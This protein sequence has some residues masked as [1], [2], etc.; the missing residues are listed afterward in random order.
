MRLYPIGC[1]PSDSSKAVSDWLKL[2][3][4][5]EA[6]LDWLKLSDISEAGSN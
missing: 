3:D 6:G 4:F 5:S 1:D 2:S